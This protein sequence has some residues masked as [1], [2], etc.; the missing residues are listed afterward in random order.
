MYLS[1]RCIS[2]I[3]RETGRDWK[4]VAKIVRSQDMVR[5][6]DECRSRA[7]EL[8]P[9]ILEMVHKEMK[10]APDKDRV[11]LGIDYLC[12]AGVF[13]ET[14]IILSSSREFPS[15]VNC[16]EEVEIIKIARGLAETAIETNKLFGID[17]PELP[18]VREKLGIG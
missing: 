17:M 5:Y 15:T 2:E 7:K 14:K 6:M 4:T 16:D 10:K 12:K 13:T 11:R 8:I 3:A 9:D 1:G 18:L